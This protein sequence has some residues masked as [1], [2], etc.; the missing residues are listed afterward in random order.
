LSEH[1]FP[2]EGWPPGFWNEHPRLRF[3]PCSAAPSG[4]TFQRWRAGRAVPLV[5]RVAPSRCASLLPTSNRSGLRL[6]CSTYCALCWLLR[7]GQAA[8]RRPQSRCRDSRAD[9]PR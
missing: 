1:L 2:Q 7:C 8:L 5:C 6:D 9:L 3:G 4:F